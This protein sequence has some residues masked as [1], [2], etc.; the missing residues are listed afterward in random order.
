MAEILV[1]VEPHSFDLIIAT[2]VF[3]HLM[4]RSM[5]RYIGT[6]AHFL[7]SSGVVYASFFLFG[8]GSLQRPDRL[9]IEFP[10]DFGT[11]R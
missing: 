4:P 3:T 8:G 1:D 11:Y 10:H 5:E 6:C 2:S 9:G 7:A